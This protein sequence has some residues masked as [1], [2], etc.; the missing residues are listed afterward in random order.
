MSPPSEHVTAR[1]SNP[2]KAAWASAALNVALMTMQIAVG[3]IAGSDALLADGIH[4]LA[5]LAADCVVLAVL[6]VVATAG[7]TNRMREARR[8]EMLASLLISALLVST[9]AEM[10]WHSA[11]YFADATGAP[12]IHA[13]AL[14][15]ALFVIVAKEALFRYMIAEAERSQSDVLLA[16]AWHARSDAVSAVIAAVEHRNAGEAPRDADRVAA[17]VIGL[18]I[19]GMGFNLSRA[20]V[21]RAGRQQVELQGGGL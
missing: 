6:H 19:I 8:M 10:L 2:R 11:A 4:T 12:S 7:N 3:W 15:V 18:M 13:S 5:D 1:R 16:S 17:M 21:R 9:G 14:A 20:A